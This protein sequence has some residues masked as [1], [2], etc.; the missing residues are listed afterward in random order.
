MTWRSPWSVGE[1][2]LGGGLR[3]RRRFSRRLRVCCGVDFTGTSGGT[4]GGWS[5]PAGM[6][7]PESH[8]RHRAI[9]P[10]RS[11]GLAHGT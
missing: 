3:A 5:E 6:G 7:G 2:V 11:S 10:A 8:E 4:S 1:S 9:A